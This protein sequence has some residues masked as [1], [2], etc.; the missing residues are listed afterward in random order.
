MKTLSHYSHGMLAKFIAGIALGA[1]G[2]NAANAQVLPEIEK[3]RTLK[4][5]IWPDYFGVTHRNPRNNAL[6]GIDI[7]LSRALARDLGAEV[8]YV[9]TDFSRL[10]DDVQA[11]R[12]HIAMMAVGVTPQRQERV[13]FSLPYLRSDLYAVASRGNAQVRRWEDIDRPGRVVVV[14]KGTFMEPVMQGLLKHARLESV[15][16]PNEREREVESGR[17]DVFITDYP[18]SRRVLAS[19]EW[20][21]VIA[22]TRPVRLTDYAYAVPKG[23]A[24]WLA[25]VNAFV[26][27]VRQDG[28]LA[29]AARRHDLLPIIVKD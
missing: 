28:R 22:P 8:T 7:D 12:C 15:L 23:E 2:L 3:T 14:Q 17:A 21:S 24:A 27:Q 26:M 9:E 25:R 18:Y 6:Q 20:A 1:L 4:V 29:D 19:F 13:D 11:R 5:C 16:R 10:L